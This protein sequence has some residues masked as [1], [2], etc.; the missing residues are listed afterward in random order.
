M[1]KSRAWTGSGVGSSLPAA[2]RP[3]S[4]MPVVDCTIESKPR[5]PDHGPVQSKAH[6]WTVTVPG[7]DGGAKPRPAK[8]PGR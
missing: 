1:A 8:A 5:R 7:Y 6:S 2:T 4:T 3:A